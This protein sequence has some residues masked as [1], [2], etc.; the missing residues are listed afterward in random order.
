MIVRIEKTSEKP[1]VP[2]GDDNGS[3]VNESKA[4]ISSEES[5]IYIKSR[6]Q[7]YS[8]LQS[9]SNDC[10][11]SFAI[12]PDLLNTELMDEYTCAGRGHSEK[13]E[14]VN[15]DSFKHLN[16]M[17]MMSSFSHPNLSELL[18]HF[19]YTLKTHIAVIYGIISG[20]L[21]EYVVELGIY[22]II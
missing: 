12:S 9:E 5:S 20:I 3:A 14:M 15:F 22:I 11:K 17:M 8:P 7:M 18:P 4:G 10:E 2:N 19:L 6:V 1:A 21:Y 16:D 13:I